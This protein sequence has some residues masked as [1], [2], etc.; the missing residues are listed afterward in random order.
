MA[1]DELLVQAQF[2]P[3]GAHL[4]LEQLAQGFHQLHFHARGQATNI[5]MRFDGHRRAAIKGDAFDHVRIK[6][7]LGQKVRAANGLGFTIKNINKQAADDFALFLRVGN[8]LKLAQKLIT[9]IHMHQWDIVMIAKQADH[10]VRF[11]GTHQAGIDEYTSELV[12]NGFV[13]QYRHN[14]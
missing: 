5:V 10:F 7:A 12:A 6:R 1:G 3:Q 8:A 13:Q 4:V 9:R 2:A 14:R 11:V